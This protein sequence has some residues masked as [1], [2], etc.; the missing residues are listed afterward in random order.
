M[1]A[2]FGYSLDRGFVAVGDEARYLPT[3]QIVRV[4]EVFSDGDVEI[5]FSSNHGAITKWRF[6]APLLLIEPT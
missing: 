1:T 3:G 6:V 4:L 5:K 2:R